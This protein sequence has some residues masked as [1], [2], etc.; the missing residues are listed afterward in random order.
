MPKADEGTRPASASR[1]RHM[2]RPPLMARLRSI[3]TPNVGLVDLI[4]PRPAARRRDL[5]IVLIVRDAAPRIEEWIEFH[6]LA[7]VEHFYVYDN[8]SMDG[9]SE[10]IAPYVARGLATVIPWHVDVADASSGRWMSQQILAYV[11]AIQTFGAGW[12]HMAFIDDDEF[13]VPTGERDLR[14]VLADLGHPSNLSLP[15]HMF[16]FNGHETAPQGSTFENFTRRAVLSLDERILFFKCIV[17]PVKVTR[18]GVHDFETTDLGRLTMNTLGQLVD[19]DA[20][21][22]RAYLTS[23]AIQLNHYFT[24][25]RAE[26]QAKIDRGGANQPNFERNRARILRHAE[27]TERETVEDRT[28]IEF[29]ARAGSHRRETAGG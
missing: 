5:A 16:G 2:K 21:R 4:P 20:R 7:G 17:D 29:L 14:A 13:L 27:A 12:R 28:A 9:T 24:R 26:L 10:V 22:S 18:A 25:S 6:L 11:H 19:G 15:W 8:L 23:E 1:S 3:F